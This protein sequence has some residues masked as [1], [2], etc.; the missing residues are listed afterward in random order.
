[1]KTAKMVAVPLAGKKLR[2]VLLLARRV[3]QMKDLQSF[4]VTPKNIE[5]TRL[6]EQD[7]PVV[8]E[9][10]DD[11]DAA[12]LIERL[13]LETHP[14]NPEEHGMH[15]LF[16]A[17]QQVESMK[18]IPTWIFAP[19]WG[20]LAAWLDIPKTPV[21]PVFIFGLR[22]VIVPTQSTNGRVLVVGASVNLDF[23]SDATTAV[24]VDMGV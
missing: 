3:L 18:A 11:L 20:L 10:T 14:F 16:G 8:D 19:S 24:A 9:G 6:T 4:S 7:E 5:I 22:L 2:D 12:Q 17:V 21:P 13:H 1:M 15:A 23:L